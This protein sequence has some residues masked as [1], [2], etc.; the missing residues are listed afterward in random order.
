MFILYLKNM[1]IPIPIYNYNNN[2]LIIL[3]IIYIKKT[4]NKLFFKNENFS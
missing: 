2:I 4:N 1:G 3:N